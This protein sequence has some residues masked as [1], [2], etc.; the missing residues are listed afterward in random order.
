VRAV[1]VAGGDPSPADA[2]WLD[3]ADLVVAVDGGAAWLA[4]IGRRPDALVGDFDSVYPD[5]VL[6]LEAG[7]AA[8]ERHQTAKDSSDCELAVAYASQRG[9]ERIVVLGALGGERLD[10]E[11]ANVLLLAGP[12]PP[13]GHEL[14]IVRGATCLRAVHPGGSLSIEA[15]P[16]SL[17]SLLPL[18]GDAKGVTTIGLRYPL[19]DEP[20]PMGSTRGLSNVVATKPASV[21]LR[22]GTLLVIE[23]GEE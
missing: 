19:R 14:R 13:A 20:L 17:V 12:P 10:H 5:L 3:D 2:G 8:I 6:R 16:G 23:T 7:G 22:R 1:L 15:R 21:Q 9:A 18:A 4:S 11:L